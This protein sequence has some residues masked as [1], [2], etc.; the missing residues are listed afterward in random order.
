MPHAATTLT[1]MDP[2]RLVGQEIGPYRII[3]LLH[4][5]PQT[6]VYR[7]RHA[8]MDRDCML[9]TCRPRLN[10]DD[11]LLSRFRREIR[12]TAALRHPNIIQF[13]DAGRYAEEGML[14]LVTEHFD[15]IDLERR[16]A[17]RP[18][19][20]DLV[21]CVGIQTAEALGAAHRQGI[22]H[23]EIA[24]ENILMNDDGYVKVSNFGLA[25]AYESSADKTVT[26]PLELLGNPAYMA[27]EQGFAPDR[28]TP[29]A[30]IY[31]LGAVLFFC[32]T[33]RP[34]YLGDNPM[35][36]I[37]QIGSPLP[38]VSRF[39]NDV[40]PLLQEVITK[41]MA[42]D[43]AA[44]FVTVEDFQRE[45]RAVLQSESDEDATLTPL[46]ATTPT[47]PSPVPLDL[48]I[49]KQIAS[50]KSEPQ[51]LAY[52]RIFGIEEGCWE[53]RLPERPVTIGRRDTC[54]IHL[55]DSVVSR[56]HATIA[57]VDGHH[58]IEDNAS[59]AG[60]LVNGKAISR[61]ELKA[62]DTI[63]IAHYILQYRNDGKYVGDLVR[64]FP[65][66]FLPSSMEA[67]YRVIHA[68]PRQIFTSGDTLPV[69]KG[70][71]FI[72]VQVAPPEDICVEVELLWPAGRKRSFL[73][74]VLGVIPFGDDLLMCLKL[75]NLKSDRYEEILKH[76]QRGAWALAPRR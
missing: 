75:H 53:Y 33:G 23:R 20:L 76:S 34:P 22:I 11:R 69:G 32:L 58:V 43:P 1:D 62:G 12:I 36:V 27:P 63:Q 47:A 30:D 10:I 14:Y 25:K 49:A 56:L 18:A 39:R 44:R 35:E 19:P 46:P 42:A 45:L 66:N 59:R 38:S 74:E 8:I 52:L 57:F 71:I 65:L 67:R 17:D 2:T 4:V 50:N 37:R 7:A 72:P 51:P 31:S 40:P 21:L 70:G 60:T 61:A 15:G 28:L 48:L 68:S 55:A 5:N 26:D 13:Y 41:A 29:Q 73:S 24:P 54:D 64:Y 3:A 6:A 16:F 9:K